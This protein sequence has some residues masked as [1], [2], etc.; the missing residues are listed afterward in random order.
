[1]SSCCCRI[2]IVHKQ[3]NFVTIKNRLHLNVLTAIHPIKKVSVSE[4]LADF[5][6]AFRFYPEE[7]AERWQNLNITL[8]SDVKIL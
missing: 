8:V 5:L 6:S 3:Q 4:A 7:E 1:M 2:T